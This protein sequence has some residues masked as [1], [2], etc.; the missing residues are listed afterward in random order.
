MLKKSLSV[1]VGLMLAGALVGAQATPVKKVRKQVTFSQDVKVGAT[2]LKS[3]RYEVSSS[4]EGLTFKRMVEDNAFPGQWNYDRKEQPVLVKATA[5]VLSA[6]SRG[7]A[8]EMPPDVSGVR[9]LKSITL[10]DTDVK[11]TISQ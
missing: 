10:E 9:V 2:V 7:T 6:K 3:G 11:F 1:V 8:L 5:S 4:D